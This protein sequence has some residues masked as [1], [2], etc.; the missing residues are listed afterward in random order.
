MEKAKK[1]ITKSL[2]CCGDLRSGSGK[3]DEDRKSLGVEE[4]MKSE[5]CVLSQK[6]NCVSILKCFIDLISEC[7][8]V[9]VLFTFVI[10]SLW[11]SFV[12]K[13]KKKSDSR[14]REG[15]D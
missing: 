4:K 11:E 8:V 9:F 13:K 1:K 10:F 15:E 7:V 3:E 12:W 5:R 6:N 14:K 2:V